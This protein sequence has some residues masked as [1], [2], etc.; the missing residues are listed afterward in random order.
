MV[1]SDAYSFCSNALAAAG[2]QDPAAELLRSLLLTASYLLLSS[3][4]RKARQAS[5]VSHVSMPWG[6]P[7]RKNRISVSS[8]IPERTSL[9]RGRR[10]E[11]GR[12]GGKGERSII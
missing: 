4:G 3:M 10:G 5:S 7:G 8:L 1:Q 9:K 6:S 12:D 2:R 11:G